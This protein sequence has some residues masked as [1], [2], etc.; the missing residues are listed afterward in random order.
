MAVET[1][2][3]TGFPGFIASRLLQRLAL[4]DMKFLLLV[5]PALIERARLEIAELATQIG[6]SSED[7]TIL[8]GDISAPD[9]ALSPHDLAFARSQTTRI[10]HLAAIYDLAVSRD[11]AQ[12]VNVA[13]ARNMNQF[14]RSL[15][16]LQQYHHVSTCYVAGKREGR[17]LETELR[18]D[19]GFRN[20]YEESK[21]LAEIEI[22]SLKDELPITIHRP[23]VV[24]GDSRTGETAKYDGVYYLIHYLLQWP[25]ALSLLNIGNHVVSLNLVPVDFIVDAMSALA[26]DDAAI[27]KTLQLAD[28]NPL[29]TYQLFNAIA[30]SING[31]RSRITV[32]PS[33]VQ[34]FLMLPPS[35]RITGLPHHGVPYFFVKQTYDSTQA[36]QLLAPHNIH[37]PPFESYV[38]TIVE[39]AACHPVL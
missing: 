37:C 21:Y 25:G 14:A 35:P 29:T 39:Y 24:C 27:G 23:A 38:D 31:G 4:K 30:N 33:W 10:F 12:R 11:L 5:Q 32:P 7:F 26:M 19:A 3:I 17:I 8:P 18:H 34:F 6:R 16:R 2:F 36:Q 15:K 20:F 28:P 22:D 9:L 1:F 13:G